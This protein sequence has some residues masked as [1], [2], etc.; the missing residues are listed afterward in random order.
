VRVTPRR[1]KSATPSET[2][3]RS[4][5]VTSSPSRRCRRSILCSSD[6]GGIAA[7]TPSSLGSTPAQACFSVHNH[8]EELT[9][10]R[11]NEYGEE[12]VREAKEEDD[13][14]VVFQ[15]E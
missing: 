11:A 8:L 6:T 4:D 5:S 2:V 7:L 14:V 13:E 12:D 10:S 9:L 3:S 15:D 1:A